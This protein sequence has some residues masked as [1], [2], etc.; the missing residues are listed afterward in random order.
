[1]EI[2]PSYFSIIPAIVRYD[3]ELKDKAKLLFS[4]ITCLTN[5]LGHCIASNDYFA[6]LY[7]VSKETISRLINQLAKKNYI[8]INYEKRGSQITKRMIILSSDIQNCQ[9]S[10]DENVI[11]SVDENVKDNNTS[12]NNNIFNNNIVHQDAPLTLSKKDLNIAFEELWSLYPSKK[13]KANISDNKKKELHK[14]GNEQ[15]KRAIQRYIDFVEQTRESG[16]ALEYKNGSTFFN[17][18]YIDYL[19]DNYTEVSPKKVVEE[20]NKLN[21]K[22][23][24]FHNFEQTTS[25]YSEKEMEEIAQRNLEKKL[26]KLGIRNTGGIYESRN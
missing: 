17:G 8:K 10:V 23:N 21:I 19:D 6:N 16:F 15:I 7:G 9:R 1:M 24:K 4:E 13:G 2:K 18:G 5:S 12:I 3:N 11:R 20:K 26:E 22:V 14:Y 25:K